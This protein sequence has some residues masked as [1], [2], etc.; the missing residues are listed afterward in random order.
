MIRSGECRQQQ[1]ERHRPHSAQHRQVPVRRCT[2]YSNESGSHHGV[3]SHMRSDEHQ[4][5]L[6][7][8]PNSVGALATRKKNL[9]RG[10]NGRTSQWY[11][12][13]RGAVAT[14]VRELE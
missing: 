12:A 1:A 9:Y 13:V 4:S 10:A 5:R 3:F 2:A 6:V 11:E 7:A 8:V 14:S